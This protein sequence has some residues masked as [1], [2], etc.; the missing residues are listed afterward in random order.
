[1]LLSGGGAKIEKQL[2]HLFDGLN[3]D[4]KGT[5]VTLQGADQIVQTCRGARVAYTDSN[6]GK[7]H[8]VPLQDCRGDNCNKLSFEN[9]REQELYEAAKQYKTPSSIII[10][11]K[12]FALCVCVLT[13]FDMR[14]TVLFRHDGIQPSHRIWIEKPWRRSTGLRPLSL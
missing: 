10:A 1:M 9:R 13:A 11:A 7:T 12:I 3:N 6:T 8:T 4:E 2:Q 5:V 14:G